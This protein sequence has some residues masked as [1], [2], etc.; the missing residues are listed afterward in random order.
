MIFVNS[1]WFPYSTSL[2]F[3]EF[4]LIA[5]A[6]CLLMIGSSELRCPS[7]LFLQA[8]MTNTKAHP[9]SWPSSHVGLAS[10]NLQF[11]AWALSLQTWRTWFWFPRIAV[12][13][14]RPCFCSS[15]CHVMK[16][17]STTFRS[18][19]VSVLRPQ[20]P[21]EPSL[22]FTGFDVRHFGRSFTRAWEDYCPVISSLTWTLPPFLL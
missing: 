6:P 3:G 15:S 13:S 7:A 1:W 5:S 12:V 22:C 8:A 4:H 16:A 10:S 2:C 17:R 19:W 14:T 18:P 11:T 20:A 21:G 9:Y